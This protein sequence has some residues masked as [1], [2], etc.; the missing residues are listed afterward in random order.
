MGQGALLQVR[1]ASALGEKAAGL[2]ACAKHGRSSPA[3]TAPCGFKIRKSFGRKKQSEL[4]NF[5]GKEASELVNFGGKEPSELVNFTV[6][7]SHRS[8]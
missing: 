2:P 5:G 6:A 8:W 3:I 4:V 7:K 1:S